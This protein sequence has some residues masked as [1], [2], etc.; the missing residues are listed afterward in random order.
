MARSLAATTFVFLS[1]ALA[2][3]VFAVD[4]AGG[5]GGGGVAG[6]ITVHVV[7]EFTGLAVADAY[8][9]VGPAPSLPFPG[10]VGRTDA[11]GA[12]TFTDIA[13]A[14]PQT[15]TAGKEGYS[16]STVA[17]VDAAVVVLP[18]RLRGGS[19]ERPT[20]S[21]DITSGFDINW[22][23][24]LWDVAVV[25][26]TFPIRE[27]LPMIDDLTSGRLSRLSPVVIE[28]FPIVGEADIPGAIYVPFQI[29]L[30]LYPLE[31][32][33]YVVY[34]ED[35]STTDLWAIYG[36]IPVFTVLG[37][38]VKPAPDLFKL[39]LGFDI[40]RYGLEEGIVVNGDGTRDFDLAVERGPNVYIPIDQG[41]PG[42]NVLVAGVA[43][44]DG[45]AGDGRLFP[46]GFAAMPGDSA[47][48]LGI[49]TL[50]AG[51]PG[52]PNYI[53]GVVMADTTQVLGSSA[54]LVRSGLAPGDTA[55]VPSFLEFTAVTATESLISWTSLA[56]PPAGL[57]PDA[58]E[59]RI[60]YVVSIPDTSPQAAPDDSIDVGELVWAFHVDGEATGVSL[61][62]L[63]TDAPDLFVDP[64]TTPEVDR[65]DAGVT[66]FRIA[67]AP[68]GFDFDEWDLADRSKYGTHFAGNTADS[69]PVP[70]S[71]YTFVA[72]PEGAA[73]GAPLAG[74]GRPSPNPFRRETTIRFGLGEPWISPRIAVYD[75]AGRLVRD[76]SAGARPGASSVTWDGRDD[77][78]RDL[79]SGLYLVR[80]FVE[81][82]TV[83]RKVMKT[84]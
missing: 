31:R 70:V 12:I 37:E 19:Y 50:G 43:D 52:D 59:L 17:Q 7:D 67:S 58:H 36:R 77:A 79:P 21:G 16:Y 49:P 25:W 56:N 63:G 61:P 39:I 27:L 72:E 1:M 54:V 48:V 57:Y 34:M 32:T 44:L 20:Y 84:R 51:V 64:F 80:I 22:N 14:G 68:G 55:D 82:K 11:G 42:V 5:F 53:F 6:A 30:I 18:I 60:S 47:G 3:A 46:S 33:P 73:S 13:L 74:L 8:V 71:P 38:L 26:H 4:G 62:L 23:D 78:G 10:N 83:T 15:V 40:R 76:L 28:N 35:Q 65:Y 75:I 9:Q 29:E 41:V 81:G 69:I 24:G 45:L 66:A 2:P